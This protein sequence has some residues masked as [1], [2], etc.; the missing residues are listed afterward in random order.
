MKILKN[1]EKQWATS[2][3]HLTFGLLVVGAWLATGASSFA[4]TSTWNG[5]SSSSSNWSD[6]ANWG[7]A[8]IAGGNSAVFSG[9]AKKTNTNDISALALVNIGLASSGWSFSGNAVTVSGFI[10]NNN[11]GT[12]TFG[13]DATMSSGGGGSGNILASAAADILKFTGVI[14]GSGSLATVAGANGQGQ[15]YLVNT[16]NSFTGP[17]GARSGKLFFYSLAVGGQN[18]SL[19][20]GTSS[21]LVGAG[22]TSYVGALI[23]LGAYDG[24]TDRGITFGNNTT[25][26]PAFTNAS[27]NNANLTLGGN[28]AFTDGTAATFAT[29]LA[30]TSRGT[31]T[32][33]GI[34]GP[35]DPTKTWAG[36]LNIY[37]PG[38]W[39]FNEQINVSGA[40]NVFTNARV[41]LGF[42]NNLSY[43]ST[44]FTNITINSGATLDVSAYNANNSIFTLGYIPGFPQTLTAG[45]VS[46]SGMDINGSLSLGTIGNTLNVAGNNVAGTLAINGDFVAG[47]G[48]INLDLETNNTSSSDLITVAGN[49]DLSQGT[50]TVN[51]K[52]FHSKLQTG[53]PYTIIAYTGNLTG[54]ASGLNVVSPSFLYTIASVDA[55]V[56]GLITVTFASSGAANLNLLWQGSQGSDWDT[57]TAN[58]FDGTASAD[59]ST[60][61]NVIFND[62]SSQTSINLVGAL[63][64]NQLTVSNNVQDYTFASSS[65]GSLAD[66]T[67]LKQGTGSLTMNTA[68]NY[69][70]GTTIS[71]GTIQVGNATALGTG[72]VTLGDA[73]SG[74]NPVR[75]GFS[76]PVVVAN[77]VVVSSNSAGPIAIAN[78]N[79]SGAPTMNGSI[80][81][82]RGFTFTNGNATVNAFLVQGGISGNG[83][84]TIQGGGGV[85]LQTGACIF[86]GNIYVI[87]GASGTTLCNI[88][89][90]LSN[91]TS[92]YLQ[93]TNAQLGIVNSAPF[94][95]LTG[96]GAVVAGPGAKYAT[97][98]S[99]GNGNGSG[100]F[101][102]IITTN[103]DGWTPYVTKNGTGTEIFTGDF[104]GATSGSPTNSGSTTINAG[105]L[106]INN[107][108]GIG[109]NPYGVSVAAAGTLAGSGLIDQSANGV[110]LNGKLSVGNAG[111][112]TGK[113]FTVVGAGTAGALRINANAV[114][115][116]DLFSGAGTGDNTA[117]PAA[118]DILNAQAPVIITNAW[119]SVS[120]A[121]SMT[122][123]AIGDKWKI[124][125]WGST[126]TG[127]FT[128]LSLPTLPSTLA[129]DTSALYTAGVIGIVA[130]VPTAPAKILGISLSGGT[131][132]ITGTNLNGGASLHYAILTA[133]NL[134]MPMANWTVLGTNAFNAD[135][136]FNYTNA[137]N[138]AQ[139]AAFFQTLVVP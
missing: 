127:V 124:A 39:A 132:V 110:T 56:S 96:N 27:P 73:G 68:N 13:M 77:P 67:L 107:T 122:A 63:S 44:L 51:L 54:N 12:S 93:G 59:F 17:A 55:S 125:S 121:S 11:S 119:L 29:I 6:A 47:N 111:D 52:A 66:A 57:V 74:A 106:A 65:G 104:T 50:V 62:T 79:S 4:Q 37:G 24:A 71:A 23:Y 108:T 99:L 43:C 25:G 123:W 89:A 94:N 137:V 84:L 69:A 90:T 130:N 7:G 30:S 91:S 5:G 19:G 78:L 81:M 61:N 35:T 40:L 33:T 20:A 1:R 64:P 85:K 3:S 38:T 114:L 46:G 82:Q 14:S 16:N 100:T 53:V 21:I 60:A 129:W 75:L 105:T 95:A 83:D 76:S 58:W 9:S 26:S 98:L 32:F 49:L 109:L 86:N 10:T 2:T 87:P 138:P 120:N 42:T 15:V 115:A 31:N 101:S 72:A 131:F 97:T 118:A 45:H 117:T 134:A 113:S 41:V 116:V 102:G 136:S 34:V 8:A 36:G 92:V 128:N 22:N 28:I 126:V 103:S 112:T 135:G 48:V 70:E 80:V 133:T 139:P 88:N 18:S